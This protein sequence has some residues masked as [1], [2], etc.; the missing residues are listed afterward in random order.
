MDLSEE[1]LMEWASQ[2]TSHT[3]LITEHIHFFT[4]DS[5]LQLMK[6]NGFVS[7][8]Y[9]LVDTDF[10]WHRNLVHQACFLR[11]EP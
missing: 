6:T 3:T 9:R 1:T 10:G 11:K 5:L 7:H 8:K 4:K 2:V